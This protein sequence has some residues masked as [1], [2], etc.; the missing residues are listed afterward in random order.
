MSDIN[1]STVMVLDVATHYTGMAVFTRGEIK[2]PIYGLCNYGNISAKHS[3]EW[4]DRCLE[5][6]SKISNVIHKVK[7]GCLVMEYPYFQ[8]GTKGAAASRSGGTLELAYLCGRIAVCW[9]YYVAKVWRDTH[10]IMTPAIL[11]KYSEWAGQVNKKITCRRL[12]EKYSIDAN[13]EST[14]NNWSDAIMMGRW[15][16]ETK[17]GH[18]TMNSNAVEVSI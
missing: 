11:T 12:K 15:F 13:P 6:S 2:P 3:D 1:R 5:M 7:P 18:S 10:E 8:G 17:M 4:Q 9:E 16:I 14:D